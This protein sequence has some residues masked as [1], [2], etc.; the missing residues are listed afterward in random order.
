[1]DNF[2][3]NGGHE[4]FGEV[5]ISGAKNAAVAIIPAALL[6]EDTVRIENI[7]QISDVQL[8]IEILSR[9]GAQIKVVNKNTLDIDTTNINYQ[10]VPYELTS[11]FRASYYLIGAMLGRFSKAEVA[12]PGGCDFGVRPIDQHVKG[13][14]MLGSQV[15]IIDGVVCAK[16]DKLVGTPIYMDVVSV[17]ATINIMLAAV[18][19]RGL[20]VIENAAKEPHI[21]DLANF[22]NSMGADVRG[23]GT[24]VIKIRGVEKMHGCTYS[25]IPDQIEAGT[26]MVAAAACGGDVLIKN[27]IPKHLESISAK[28]E[29]AGAEVIEYDDAVRVTRF[30]ALTKCNVK[31]MPHPGFPTDMQPQMA[32][33]LSI[34]NGTSILSESVWDNRF[35]YVQ[36]L[37]RMGADIQVDGKVAVIVGVPKLDGVTVRATDLRAGA[38]MI[39]AGLVADGTTTVEDTIYVERGYEDVVE[40]F[41]SIG[42]DIR[43]VAVK[44]DSAVQTAG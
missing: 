8:I 27:V 40:K 41:A 19:A 15:D 42:A 30:K 23:A 24:D 34:A 26:Y 11:H 37:L 3:I 38:A 36:Q 21:V 9:M 12:L 4:L 35:Q 2:V 22:L 25:I 13:F 32:V 33:L 31:T 10:S 18:K 43:R 16:A 20:T 17:G 39:I 7:P 28:L 6:A 5:E 14:K 44:E 29:E 1:M